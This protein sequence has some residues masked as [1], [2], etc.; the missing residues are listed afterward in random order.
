M[1]TSSSCIFMSGNVRAG[2]RRA[3]DL[4][5][6]EAVEDQRDVGVGQQLE[7]ELV[8]EVAL[9]G[10]DDRAVGADVLGVGEDEV[11]AEQVERLAQDLRL[12]VEVGS[13]ERGWR[14]R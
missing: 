7:I 8:V 11:V 5:L 9:A 4:V 13:G 2:T 1:S 14:R 12:A 10:G 3:G 6:G